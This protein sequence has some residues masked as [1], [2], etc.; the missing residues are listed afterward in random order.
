MNTSFSLLRP[1]CKAHLILLMALLAGTPLQ[2]VV[3]DE[4]NDGVP[5][6]LD[7][8]PGSVAMPSVSS[9]FI[10]KHAITKKQLQPGKA[11][12]DE[13]GCEADSDGDGVLDSKDYCPDDSPEAISMGVAQN[14]CPKHSDFDGTPDYRDHCP[15]TPMG[16]ATDRQGCPR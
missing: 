9:D 7:K 13:N 3:P 14:G 10:N 2:A 5:D 1:L 4:D 6:T 8:C 12:V 15:G 11:G 16:V